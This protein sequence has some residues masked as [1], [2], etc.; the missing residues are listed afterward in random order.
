MSSDATSLE[1]E[2][3]SCVFL[4]LWKTRKQQNSAQDGL[5]R[6]CVSEGS[7]SRGS[8][9]SCRA[10]EEVFVPG[11]WGLELKGSTRLEEKPLCRGEGRRDAPRVA[12]NAEC[13]ETM[14]L[15]AALRGATPAGMNAAGSANAGR[16]PVAAPSSW[17]P[18]TGR[19]QGEA[20]YFFTLWAAFT[21]MTK[22]SGLVSLVGDFQREL[23]M[24]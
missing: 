4:P 19:E 10:S 18:G 11:V 21:S 8:W 14:E 13:H 16:S 12:P 22:C 17:P 5:R 20:I 3:K 6:P 15:C 23:G 2:T 1:L 9:G 7:S 24:N